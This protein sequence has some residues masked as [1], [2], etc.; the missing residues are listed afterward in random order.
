MSR[1]RAERMDM[2]FQISDE[3]RRHADSF[4]LLGMSVN[5]DLG[6]F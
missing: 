6:K 5:S 3:F 4:N 1:A 2:A